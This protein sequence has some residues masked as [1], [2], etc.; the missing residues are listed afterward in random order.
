[1]ITLQRLL[2]EGLTVGLRH[3]FNLI[4][5]LDGVAIRG[6]SGCVDDLVSEALSNGLDVAER[7]LA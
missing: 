1:M 3:S 2:Y 4:L 5:L 6:A 7:S